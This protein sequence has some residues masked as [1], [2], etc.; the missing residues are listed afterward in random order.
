MILMSMTHLHVEFMAARVCFSSTGIILL[1]KGPIGA[2]D[3]HA[4]TVKS[5][6]VATPLHRV[7]LEFDCRSTDCSHFVKM[8]TKR[9]KHMIYST[10]IWK[11]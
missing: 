2:Y 9:W 4:L 3:A 1:L 11:K 5:V 7:G 10:K 6:I 8:K